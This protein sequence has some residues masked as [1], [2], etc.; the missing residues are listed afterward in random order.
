MSAA[1]RTAYNNESPARND[2]IEEIDEKAAV[3]FTFVS[4]VMVDSFAG[5]VSNRAYYDG[6]AKRSIDR[7]FTFFTQEIQNNAVLS[8]VRGLDFKD[9]TIFTFNNGAPFDPNSRVF[10]QPDDYFSVGHLL[11]G[12]RAPYLTVWTKICG[13][14]ANTFATMDMIHPCTSTDST[15]RSSTPSVQTS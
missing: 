15:T 11:I 6:L 1:A 4:G 2:L 7:A 10:S 14:S 13:F 3:S 12:T 5:F 8:G 9:T